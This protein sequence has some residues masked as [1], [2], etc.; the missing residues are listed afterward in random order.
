MAEQ[1]ETELQEPS[2]ATSTEAMETDQ[3]LTDGPKHSTQTNSAAGE[4]EEEPQ[5]EQE[6]TLTDH[7]NKKLLESFLSRLDSGNMS[8]PPQTTGQP[9]ENSDEFND[10]P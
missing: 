3:P 7:L 10:D 2:V 5:P 8:F 1:G 4:E 9:S 6:R